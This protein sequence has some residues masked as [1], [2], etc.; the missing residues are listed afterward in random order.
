MAACYYTCIEPGPV[1][2]G[3][4]LWSPFDALRP[5]AE[6]LFAPGAMPR[7]VSADR[8]PVPLPDWPAAWVIAAGLALAPDERL[9]S[10]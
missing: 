3:G 9:W 1:P 5:S 6:R 2:Q 8:G 7:A 4:E 10:R